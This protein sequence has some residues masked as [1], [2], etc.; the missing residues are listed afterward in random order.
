MHFVVV[1]V[2]VCV[3]CIF[4][5]SLVKVFT[6]QICVPRVLTTVSLLDLKMKA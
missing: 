4:L 6:L 2:V 5:C 1:V 3:V